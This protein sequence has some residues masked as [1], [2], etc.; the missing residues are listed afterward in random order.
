MLG[1]DTDLQGGVLKGGK[2]EVSGGLD[3]YPSFRISSMYS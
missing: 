1:G 3:A 2:A